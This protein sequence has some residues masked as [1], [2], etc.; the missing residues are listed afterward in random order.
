MFAVAKKHERSVGGAGLD[1]CGHC[2]LRALFAGRFRKLAIHVCPEDGLSW[3]FSSAHIV[4]VRVLLFVRSNLL[5]F[6]HR[7]CPFAYFIS[8]CQ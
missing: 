7:F 6:E 1:L 2:P 3:G 4:I 5:V 8:P